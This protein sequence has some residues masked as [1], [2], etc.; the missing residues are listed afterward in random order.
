MKSTHI[1]T[2]VSLCLTIGCQQQ[3]QPQSEP[4]SGPPVAG[5]FSD[6]LAFLKDHTDVLLL[7]GSTLDG[8]SP[9][10]AQVAISPSMQGRVLT[11]T[12]SGPDGLSLGW[13]NHDLIASGDTLEH[14]NPYGGEDRFWIGPEGGQFS[15]FFKKG[16]PFDLE[17]WFTPA[18]FD[19][20]PFEV[21]SASGQEVVFHKSLALENYSGAVFEVGV[22]RTIRLFDR[23]QIEDLLDMALGESVRSV[24]FESDNVIKNSGENAWKEDTGL[25]SIWILGMFNPSPATTIVIPFKEGAD[26]EL[27]P[28]VNDAYF[29][30]VPADRLVVQPG[31]L[32]FKGDGLYRSKIGL[33]PMRATEVAGSYDAANR[34]LT[35]VQYTKPPDETRYV[36][37]MWEIQDRPYGGDVLNSYNDG[38]LGPGQ[39]G[40][41]PFYELETSSPA[42]ALAPGEEM[43]HIHRTFHFQGDESDLNAI[44]EHVLGVSLSQIEGALGD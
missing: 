11:S 24:A 27:G 26:A 7:S 43:R 5:S 32:F 13:I 16:D 22:E 10:A 36:N 9:A 31:V 40:L 4:D 29:G 21:A 3:P 12:L 33:T 30:K 28:V 18:G 23:A 8:E 14:M 17:H 35:L 6:D 37:S 42:A 44:A 15:V 19:T 20:E 38:P 2:V 25:L 34:V 39:K 41:G 1:I